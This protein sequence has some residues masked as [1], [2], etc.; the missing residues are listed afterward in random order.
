MTP[1]RDAANAL[2]TAYGLALHQRR[3]HA[4]LRTLEHAAQ[5]CA[6]IADEEGEEGR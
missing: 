6:R 1:Y 5:V 4:E 2:W 3:P